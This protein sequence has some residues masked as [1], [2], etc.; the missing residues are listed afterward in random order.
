MKIEISFD[1]N[2][3]HFHF[4]PDDFD[5]KI[6]DKPI[7]LSTRSC[8][9]KLPFKIDPEEIHPDLLALSALLLC[10]PFVSQKID[11]DFS[12]SQEFYNLCRT[13]LGLSITGVNKA[14]IRRQASGGI[15]ALAYSG[16]VDSSAALA[17]MPEKK[18][19]YFI[20]RVQ[21]YG[22]RTLYNKYAA[23]TAFEDV[24][25]KEPNAHRIQTDFEY[26][27]SNV[28]FPVDQ[29]NVDIPH[30][31]A[32]PALLMADNCSIDSIS[33]GVIM[34]SIYMV[35]HEKYEDYALSRHYAKWTPFF[36]HV[37]INLF[38][39]TA[40]ITEVGT[41]IITE[42]TRFSQYIRSCMR[43]DENR[44]CGKC[45]KCLRKSLLV[46]S[47]H[48]T[49]PDVSQIERNLDSNPVAMNI[50]GTINQ[51]ENIYRYIASQ[52]PKNKFSILLENRLIIDGEDCSWMERWFPESIQ[53]IPSK[54]RFEFLSRL[55]NYLRPMSESDIFF[56]KS[57]D[58]DVYRNKNNAAFMN[59]KSYFYNIS[60]QSVRKFIDKNLSS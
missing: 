33:Y 30:P 25:K 41:T 5:V 12:V 49:C 22:K 20:D 36:E 28:G 2:I 1:E 55:F 40:G 37:G 15:P 32:V 3:V 7:H 21:P 29:L 8:Y 47:I 59:W 45:I 56:V 38:F 16:G 51:H 17:L 10:Y 43:G 27:R 54:Y 50:Y 19:V 9:F 14:I 34:E 60:S 58:V 11:F 42:K 4:Y 35:G 13:N 53:L 24:N 23:I 31:V 39:P 18:L 44:A 46:H 26:L 6:F 57:W 52:L 48:G